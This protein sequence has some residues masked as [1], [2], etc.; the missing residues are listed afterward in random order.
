[1]R[2][3]IIDERRWPG[4]ARVPGGRL[5][6]VRADLARRGFTRALAR[7]GVVDVA[8]DD[9]AG[10]RRIRIRDAALYAR[11]ADSGWLGLGE[12]YLAGEW[13]SD[14]LPETLAALL[15][16]GLDA[17]PGGR[18]GRGLRTVAGPR[19]DA[20]EADPGGDLPASL[21]ALYAGPGLAPGS[22]LFASGPAT[23]VVEQ[24]PLPGPGA[25]RRGAPDQVPV[26]VTRVAD[27]V[28]PDRADLPA[29][30]ARRVAAMLRLAGVRAGDRVLEWPAAG[31]AAAIA[32]AQAGAAAD[33][34]AVSDDAAEAVLAAAGAAGLAPAV[35]VLRAPDALPGPRA[36]PSDYDAI[37]CVERLETLGAAGLRTWLRD[38]ERLLAERG[39]IVVQAAVATGDFDETA[40]EALQLTR[41]YVW[42]A[43]H[44]PSL[45]ALQRTVARD[46][47]LRIVSR[48][49][50]PG[51][52]A[53]SLR[54]WR[55]RFE[56]N[57]RQAA[58]LGYDR[59][60]RRLWDYHLALQ[61]ALVAS[62]RLDMVLLELAAAP[63]PRR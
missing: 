54:L 4:V 42:P 14:T 56:A 47:G 22:A 2:G 48:T 43:L 7:A 29:A 37:L 36:F 18:L 8:A 49:H 19:P 50:F 45:A 31:G 34:L 33:V 3:A 38:A 51:H 28:A 26:E 44:H 23:T 35:R 41:S 53:A 13:D 61:E 59:V 46:T 39:R 12:S 24:V 62:G 21:V 10:G 63:R 27:P 30:Q 9:A 5:A 16:A 15:A 60:Y 25:G 17:G 32:A 20:A 58:G 57:S 40:A 1:M 55:A 11:I 52:W 6:G